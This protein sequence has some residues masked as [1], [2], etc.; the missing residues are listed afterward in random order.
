MGTVIEAVTTEFTQ[1]ERP[2]TKE[3][4]DTRLTP[5]VSRKPEQTSG[6]REKRDEPPK[7][8]I[9]FKRKNVS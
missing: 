4:E 9:P 3:G 1:N 6:R 8:V 2:D 5:T 7:D